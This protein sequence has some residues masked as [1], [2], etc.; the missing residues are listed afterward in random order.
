AGDVEADQLD[1]AGPARL[2]QPRHGALGVGGRHGVNAGQ[3]RVGGAGAGGDGRGL[4]GFV[5][6]VL[7]ADVLHARVLFELVDEALLPGLAERVARV[8]VEPHDLALA[9]GQLG[10]LGSGQPPALDVVGDDVGG[11]DRP[12]VDV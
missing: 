3:P 10:H 2:P 9:A 6:A 4:G 8:V 12:V 11:H 7:G 5:L 1:L